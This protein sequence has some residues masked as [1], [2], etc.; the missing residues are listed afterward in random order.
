MQVLA[1]DSWGTVVR[2]VPAQAAT[3]RTGHHDGHPGGESHLWWI[4]SVTTL[5]AQQLPVGLLCLLVTVPW[6]GQG[7]VIIVSGKTAGIKGAGT[8][9]RHGPWGGYHAHGALS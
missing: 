1:R 2:A 9:G 5:C 6:L 4:S 8:Q 3:P 7:T